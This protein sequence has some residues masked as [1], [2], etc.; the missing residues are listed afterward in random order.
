MDSRRLARIAAMSLYY[1][2]EIKD[3]AD[4]Y[5][6]TLVDFE[7]VLERAK[8]DDANLQY[9]DDALTSLEAH[10]EDMDQL[11]SANLKDWTIE[12]ISKVDLSILRL[13]VA[14]M[15]YMEDIPVSVS[16]NEAVEISKLYSDREA[17]KFINGILRNIS[18][19][20]EK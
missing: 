12:R 7:D 2:R 4:E 14:E 19:T 11:I 5:S 9:I 8:L 20:L 18:R 16:V 6:T 1:E 10:R 17:Y 13:A 3:S 15:L